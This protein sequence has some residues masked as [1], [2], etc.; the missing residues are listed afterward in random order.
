MQSNIN[1]RYPLTA[2]LGHVVEA[3]DDLRQLQKDTEQ[4]LEEQ[5]RQTE[6]ERQLRGRMERSLQAE[7]KL[8]EEAEASIQLY[9]E[10]LDKLRAESSQSSSSQAERSSRIKQSIASLSTMITEKSISDENMDV[11][12]QMLAALATDLD[13]S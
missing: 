13:R 9:K 4:A 6:A 1:S 3:L 5:C 7:S 8:R 10:I 12:L 11:T 2:R